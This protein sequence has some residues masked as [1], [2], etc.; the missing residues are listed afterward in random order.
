MF[1][2][3]NRLTEENFFATIRTTSGGSVWEHVRTNRGR[4]SAYAMIAKHWGEEGK[5]ENFRDVNTMNAEDREGLSQGSDGV[6]RVNIWAG[7]S[8]TNESYSTAK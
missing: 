6:L 3:K 4:A 7:C 5:I 2:A 8:S 1:T